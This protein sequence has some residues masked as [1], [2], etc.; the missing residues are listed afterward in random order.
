MKAKEWIE[1]LQTLDSV[2]INTNRKDSIEILYSWYNHEIHFVN[3]TVSL[4]K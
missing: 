2:S 3:Y 1:R 4:N